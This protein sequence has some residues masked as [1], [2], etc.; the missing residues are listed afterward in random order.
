M[1]FFERATDDPQTPLPE[2]G[3]EIEIVEGPPPEIIEN[4]DGSI[5]IIEAED[6]DRSAEMAEHDSNLAEH[7]SPQVL[8]RIGTDLVALI[9]DDENSREDW[10]EACKNGLA[11]LGI[12]PENTNGPWAGSCG[13]VSTML[14]EALV[15]FQ[16]NAIME[17]FPAAGPAKTKIIGRITKAIQEQA[18]RVQDKVNYT[19]T[20]EI[21]D[22]R[23]DTEKLLW[24]L[25]LFGSG[26]RKVFPDPVYQRP[27]ATYVP[28]KDF[29][30]PYGATN[31]S[32][33]PRYTEVLHLFDGQ[34]KRLQSSGY[35]LSINV[36]DASFPSDLQQGIDEI[37]KQTDSSSTQEIQE[38]YECHVDLDI[39]HPALSHPDQVPKPYVVTLTTSGVILAVRR[40][41]AE[42]D[43]TFEKILHYSKYTF[44][45]GFG[46]YGY[47]LLHLIG[48]S[49]EAAT[50]IE[51]QLIDAGTLAN[52]PGGY[53]TK[54]LRIKN[55]NSPHMPGE[56]RDM[57]LLNGG[58]AADN[59]FALP[60]KEPS[61]VLLQL[62]GQVEESGRRL[63]S[64]ADVEIGDIGSQ[65]PVGT[66]LAVM[67]RAM[68]VMS[69]IQ[70]RLHASM[71]DEFRILVRV[72][73]DFT[74]DEYEYDV[75]GGARTIKKVDFDRRVDVVPVSDPNA[76]T[77]SQRVTLYQMAVQLSQMA[78]QI[79]DLA[80]LHRQMLTVAGIKDVDLIIPN[81]DETKPMDPVAENMAIITMKPIKAFEW[82]D[83]KAHIAVHNAFITDPATAAAMGQNPQANAIFAAAQSHM[84]EHFAYLYRAEIEMELGV[85]L[86]GLDQV[87]PGDVE[88]QLS[89]AVARAAEKLAG[90]HK[91]EAAAAE[92]QQKAQ[93]PVLQLQAAELELK[94]AS[95]QQKSQADK[96]RTDAEMNATKTRAEVELERIRSQER[97]SQDAAI[98]RN[99]QFLAKAKID[100]PMQQTEMQKLKAQIAQIM[101]QIESMSRDDGQL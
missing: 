94:K 11:L 7:L 98:D 14:A 10:Y 100:A 70:A 17:I 26:F 24:G 6:E 50:K 28:A 3:I 1:S 90:K 73:R 96:M 38:L 59:F 4:E 66:T 2:A 49:A 83:H 75:E 27:N 56:W 84:A 60:Y 43:P 58:K 34:L 74:P 29:I 9:K 68:K 71:H 80:Q 63:G 40:N 16:S 48:G 18:E 32:T 87:L 42:G 8:A 45:P 79:Y 30:M 76:A 47:G 31:L 25:G 85:P 89:L 15:R 101:M 61:T 92:A 97:M 57:E 36:N 99:Q 23:G 88:S 52:L 72:I 12:K 81:K 35:Y 5:E 93:D 53:K 77:M 33:C 51:R 22:Y 67:E 41:W 64:I 65:A 82:Q 69:A 37:N 20:E 19:L 91:S 78:P 86:P 95:L 44:V 39:D 62:L 46:A 13:L 55:D 54:G 21:V